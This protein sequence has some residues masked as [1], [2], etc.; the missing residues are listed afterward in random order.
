M[1]LYLCVWGT[2]GVLFGVI[3]RRYYREEKLDWP[4]GKARYTIAWA[5]SMTWF[6]A[7]ALILGE[8]D[9]RGS[10]DDLELLGP[11]ARAATAI[12]SLYHY[13]PRKG[14]RMILP[15]YNRTQPSV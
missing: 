5:A 11:L 4:N 9:R 10:F 8:L 12:A 6:V 14:I 15:A 7:S 13:R 2:D 1:L 3:A